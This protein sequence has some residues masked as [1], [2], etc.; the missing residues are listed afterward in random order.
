[1]QYYMNAVLFNDKNQVIDDSEPRG[2]FLDKEAAENFARH[3]VYAK[4]TNKPYVVIM[5]D[6]AG[7]VH[8]VAIPSGSTG[9]EDLKLAFDNE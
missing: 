4:W 3:T 5:Y 2:P 6:D 1:M 8:L 7:K 9:S